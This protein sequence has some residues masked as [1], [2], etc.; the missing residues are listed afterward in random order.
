MNLIWEKKKDKIRQ[1]YSVIT[2]KDLIF[3]EG[4][5]DL[6]FERLRNKLGKTDLEI[7]DMIVES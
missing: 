2:D 1:K 4:K 3:A 5:E 6:M 7:L